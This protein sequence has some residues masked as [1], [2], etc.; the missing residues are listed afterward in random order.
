LDT[1]ITFSVILPIYHS[2]DLLRRSLAAMRQVVYPADRFEVLVPG[3]PDD[4][5]SRRIV[6]VSAA[7]APFKMAYVPVAAATRAGALNGA[8]AVSRGKFLAFA[9]D[10]VFVEPDWLA[11]LE[12]IFRRQPEAGLVGGVDTM[13]EKTGLFDLA[14]DAVLHSFLGG[15]RSRRGDGLRAGQYYPRL[16]NMTMPRAVA[17]EAAIVRADGS[18]EVFNAALPVH[19]DVELGE[20]VRRTGRPLVFVPEVKVR[21]RRKTTFAAMVCRDFQA[22]R[23][24]R[25]EG[26]HRWGHRIL[27]AVLVVGVVLAAGSIFWP[28]PRVGL[29]ALAVI[30]ALTLLTLGIVAA[31]RKRKL[32]VLFLAPLVAASLHLA[33]AT[34]YLV[35]RR[36]IAAPVSTA[37]DRRE[38]V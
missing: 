36:T 12:E 25:T 29:A 32:G 38:A 20:R 35:G 16:W 1:E 23:T 27:A 6:E 9:D 5:D 13:T 3:R 11:R 18:R 31:I 14:F 37:T 4:G 10:D 30:Y 21:H 24:C 33:R 2:G 7:D 19:E 34:G 17:D 15:G 28:Q 22:A 26:L 8:I